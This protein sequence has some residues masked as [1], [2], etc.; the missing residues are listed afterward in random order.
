MVRKG[1]RN[2]SIPEQLFIEL[3]NFVKQSEGK[4]VSVAEVVREAIREFL[5]QHEQ[6]QE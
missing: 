1:Y 3:Q 6:A 5:E 2:L 4:Y